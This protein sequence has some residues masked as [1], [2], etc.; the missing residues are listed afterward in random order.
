VLGSNV[1]NA[2]CLYFFDRKIQIVSTWC[3]SSAANTS[4]LVDLA[5]LYA[6][7]INSRVVQPL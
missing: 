5:A 4:M 7:G 6:G 3:G 2:G 1:M